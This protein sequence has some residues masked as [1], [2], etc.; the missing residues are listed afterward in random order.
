MNEQANEIMQTRVQ[1]EIQTRMVAK[2]LSV[3]ALEKK[4]GLRMSAVRNILRGQS[5]RPSAEILQA[6]ARTLECSLTDLLGE[7]YAGLT[8]PHNSESAQ[9]SKS[10]P[11]EHPQLFVEA[12]QVITDL[13]AEKKHNLKLNQVLE[14][15]E[16]VYL[17]SQHNDKNNKVDKKFASWVVDRLV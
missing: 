2:N 10:C 4:A 1:R 5:K 3:A 14:L 16:Q 17:Y 12:S 15:V 9:A 7:N 11:F 13:L 8:Q 6:I